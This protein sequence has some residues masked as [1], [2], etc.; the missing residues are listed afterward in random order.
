SSLS[1]PAQQADQVALQVELGGSSS[2]DTAGAVFGRIEAAVLDLPGVKLVES[3]FQEVG[4]TVTVHLDKDARD[5]VSPGKVREE[6]RLAT[7][8]LPNVEIGNVDLA[9][10]QGGGGGDSD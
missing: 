8:S 5:A 2:L 3:Q 1:P 4:G 6:V 7:R 10:G 9:A